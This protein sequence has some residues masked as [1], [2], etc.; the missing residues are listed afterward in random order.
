[1]RTGVIDSIRQSACS[2]QVA[3]T[4]GT[5]SRATNRD[6]VATRTDPA[7]AA[8]SCVGVIAEFVEADTQPPAGET[9]NSGL[10]RIAERTAIGSG[11][12]RDTGVGYDQRHTIG[13]AI[14][15]GGVAVVLERD[16]DQVIGCRK[17]TLNRRSSRHVGAVVGQTKPAIDDTWIAKGAATGGNGPV[18]AEDTAVEVIR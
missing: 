14:A 2:R 10:L 5:A 15:P 16:T 4:V 17:G 18:A 7:A 12:R 8:F 13:A 3:I 11:L 1:G 6:R 9:G